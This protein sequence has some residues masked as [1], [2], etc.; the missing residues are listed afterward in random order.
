MKKTRNLKNKETLKTKAKKTIKVLII[1]LSLITICLSIIFFIIGSNAS[2][3]G[4]ELRQE[5]D[6]NKNLKEIEQRLKR[7]ITN[8]SAIKNLE[9]NPQIINMEKSTDVIF[10]DK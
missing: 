2:Q 8:Y 10:I 4:S 9:E 1:T 7:D 5:Q 6:I 3:N